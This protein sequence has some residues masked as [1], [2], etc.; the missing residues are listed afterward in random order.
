MKRGGKT[1]KMAK[2]GV[3]PKTDKVPSD[4]TSEKKWS[5]KGEDHDEKGEKVAMK[6]GGGVKKK[7]RYAS[8]GAVKSRGD[9]IAERG[10]TR[11]TFR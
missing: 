5:L 1:H 9:G 2:G 11:G 6:R 10:H 3:T 4:E 8:G 7:H